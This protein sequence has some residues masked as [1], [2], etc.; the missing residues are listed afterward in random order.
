VILSRDS[1]AFAS[2]AALTMNIAG[3]VKDWILIGLS[4][5]LYEAPVSA[6][7]LGGYLLA[8]AAV[9]YYNFSKI[10]AAM[11]RS[12]AAEQA[13]YPPWGLPCSCQF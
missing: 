5:W 13:R 9:C 2:R 7:N 3:V 4:A 8:F 11:A 6:L 1:L 12:A 10:N